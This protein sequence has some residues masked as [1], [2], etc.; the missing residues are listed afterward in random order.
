MALCLATTTL[1]YSGS[2][3]HS[4]GVRTNVRMAFGEEEYG[5]EETAQ[6]LANQPA[7]FV[8]GARGVALPW[9]SDEIQDTEGL[10]KLA[11]KLNPVV[12]YYDPFQIGET[13]KEVRVRSIAATPCAWPCAPLR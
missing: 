6:I 11:L 5:P 1:A 10:K 2:M 12:G 4:A 7:A 9:D 3:L 13:G 8:V